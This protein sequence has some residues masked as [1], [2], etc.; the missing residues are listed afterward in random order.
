MAES[1]FSPNG[2][3]KSLKLQVHVCDIHDF[4]QN[5]LDGDYT[6]TK[7]KILR[8]YCCTKKSMQ[9]TEHPTSSSQETTSSVSA[10][11]TSPDVHQS[12]SSE[13][14]LITLDLTVLQDIQ[15][16]DIL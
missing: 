13:A 11:I 4:S 3:S 6:A 1:L 2:V 16:S 5:V 14:I 9:D 8:L 10:A 12:Q 7:V 15:V